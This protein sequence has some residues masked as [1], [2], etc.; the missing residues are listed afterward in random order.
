MGLCSI[1]GGM[2]GGIGSK[3]MRREVLVK[4]IEK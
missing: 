4:E 3:E 2:R 1:V